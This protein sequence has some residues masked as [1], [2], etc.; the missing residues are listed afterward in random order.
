MGLN[1]QG[2]HSVHADPAIRITDHWKKLHPSDTAP[3][4]GAQAG[5]WPVE[6][7]IDNGYAMATAWYQDLEPDHKDG[8]KTA[9]RSTLAAELKIKPEDWSAIAAWT[10]GMSRIMDFLQLE[11]RVDAKKVVLT[12]HSRIGKAALWAAANDKR[13]A[14]VISNNSGEGGAALARRNYGETVERIN[15]AF[16]H[17]FVAP[18]KQ[19][20]NAIDQLPVDQHM[21]LALVAPRPLYV[22]SAVED[23][24]ADPKGELLSAV[25]ASEVYRLYGKA[26]VS[27]S[28]L[29]AL[30]TPIGDQVRYHIRTGKH[31]ITEYDWR[32]YILFAN[33]VLR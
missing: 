14:V 29:P 5:R 25:A 19:Y 28:E 6:L 3:Q 23:Q 15:T 10:W 11:D 12:G 13:F 31:D 32:E 7:L 26:G 2:N 17:W 18:Y 9:I 27:A 4:R 24:W 20:N 30:N 8:W 21:L 22:A 16:P 1:F 33:K